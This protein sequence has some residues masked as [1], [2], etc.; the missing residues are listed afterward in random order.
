MCSMIY[1]LTFYQYKLQSLGFMF[2]LH[3]KSIKTNDGN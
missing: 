1:C 2:D 3:K